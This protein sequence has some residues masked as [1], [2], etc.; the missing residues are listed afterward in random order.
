MAIVAIVESLVEGCAVAIIRVL[1]MAL[2]KCVAMNEVFKLFRKVALIVEDWQMGK[3]IEQW[4]SRRGLRGKLSWGQ[5]RMDRRE[6][7]NARWRR[8]NRGHSRSNRCE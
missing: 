2:N 1:I 5:M 6:R 7:F 4:C 3:T 8:R